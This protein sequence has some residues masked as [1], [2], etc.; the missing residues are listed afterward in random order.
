MVTYRSEQIN[1]IL[2]A[3]HKSVEDIDASVVV[4]IDGLLVEAYPPS[5]EDA[6]SDQVAALT[7]T[8]IGLAEKTLT[9]LA[10]GDVQRLL[11]EGEDGVMVV[12]PSGKRAAL[13]VLVKK[14]A[15]LGMAMYAVKRAAAEVADILG[16]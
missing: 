10:Q 15:K 6:T 11:L 14:E 8:L 3:M 7:A 1:R 2:R 12:Y 9:R 4:N 5:D 16:D 13:A